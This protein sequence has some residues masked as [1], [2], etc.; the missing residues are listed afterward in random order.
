MDGFERPGRDDDL[1]ALVVTPGAILAEMNTVD[2]AVKQLDSDVMAS[3]A[4]DA[5]K[6]SWRGFVTEWQ[7]FYKDHA[8][9][10]DR[11]WGAPYEKTLDYRRRVGEWRTA[12][13]REGGQASGPQISVPGGER[14]GP[15]SWKAVLV[16]A[17][18]LLVAGAILGRKVAP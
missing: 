3:A 1:G 7:A 5:F 11:L 9:W 15:G 4:R 18:G 12:F 8:S 14:E 13:E 10:T 16:L 6:K 2:A 17:G